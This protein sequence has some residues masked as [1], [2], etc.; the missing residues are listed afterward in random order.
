MEWMPWLLLKSK[1][2]GES[3]LSGCDYV[4]E[5]LASALGITSPKFVDGEEELRK[6]VE[7]QKVHDAESA[8]EIRELDTWKVD[9]QSTATTITE[10]TSPTPIMIQEVT[11]KKPSA[12]PR[13]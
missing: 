8:E 5:F 7:E 1:Q 12:A 10:P 2:T 13:Y 6:A 4:G 9:T 3:V 11:E